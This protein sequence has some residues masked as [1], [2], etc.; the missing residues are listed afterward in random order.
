M[1]KAAYSALRAY[2]PATCEADYDDLAPC[3]AEATQAT[4]E[5]KSSCRCRTKE[6]IPA[7]PGE[8]K[9]QVTP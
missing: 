7:R 8:Q 5:V 2:V 9:G 4:G 1:A 3:D 6:T